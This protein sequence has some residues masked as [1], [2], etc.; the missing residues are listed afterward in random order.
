M[1]E[2]SRQAGR[3]ALVILEWVCEQRRRE[4]GKK[5][6]VRVRERERASMQAAQER[7]ER[8]G[9]ERAIHG[10]QHRMKCQGQLVKR[11]TST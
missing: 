3:Q 8:E 5:R 4:K 7:R 2:A 1:R 10:T 11:H 9:I 6:A